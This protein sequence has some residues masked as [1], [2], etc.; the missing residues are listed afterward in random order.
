MFVRYYIDKLL[1]MRH[2]DVENL[3][4]SSILSSSSSSTTL[5]TLPTQQGKQVTRVLLLT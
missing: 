4:V 3:S 2:E 1:G 5:H